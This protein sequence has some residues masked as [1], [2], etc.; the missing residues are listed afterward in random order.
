MEPPFESDLLDKTSSIP[1]PADAVVYPRPGAAGLVRRVR[2]AIFAPTAPLLGRPMPSTPSALCVH[3]VL[4]GVQLIFG[5]GSVVG[6]LGV[7]RFN[8]LLFALIRELIAALLLMLI[9]WHRDGL[10]LPRRRDAA[11]FLGCGFCLFSNQ[12]SFIIGDKLAGAVI[13]SAWQP[14]QPVFT[15]L[16]S[17]LLGW[18]QPTCLKLSGIAISCCGAAFMVLYGRGRFGDGAEVSTFLA[19]NVLFFLNCLGTS[20]YVIVSKVALGRGYPPSTLIAWS[21]LIGAAMMAAT[22]TGLSADCRVVAFVCPP[23]PAAAEQT[24]PPSF[25]CGDTPTSCE[26]WAV[27]PGAIPALAYWILGNSVAAYWLLTW[28]NEHARAGFVLAYC[29][30]QPLTAAALSVLII[31]A[32]G[33]EGAG[34]MLEMPGW[35]A[36]GGGL[37][38][39]TGLYLIL[40]DGAEQ[41]AKDVRAIQ[42]HE[43]KDQDEPKDR[44]FK[45]LPRP[46]CPQG[47]QQ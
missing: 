41:H 47:Q 6:K 42:G 43:L 26:A 30:L 32:S 13:G 37:A 28:A 44:E 16:I 45:D 34:S 40:R 46:Q 33:G 36:L 10:L 2:K 8:P 24:A 5:V 27:P 21:Y 9:A 12:A 1:L 18:E 20:L 22:A 25:S 23:P 39:V 29:A 3:A 7:A 17:L 11:V 14:T 38:I 19:G 4:I 31:S 35:N 15:L